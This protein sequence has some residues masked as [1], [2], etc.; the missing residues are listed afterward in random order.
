MIIDYFL[1]ED[2]DS[3]TF[4][5]K[6]KDDKGQTIRK[7]SNKKDKE[8]PGALVM[9][10]KKGYNRMSW[11]L[12][13]E[14]YPK[15]PGLSVLPSLN[16]HTVCPG[17]YQ[18]VLIYD[19]DSVSVDLVLQ[20]YPGIDA[21]YQDFQEQYHFLNEIESTFREVHESVNRVN[22]IK[23]QLSGQKA[24]FKSLAN[25]E[26]LAS[27]SDSIVKAIDQW[28]G[29]LIQPKQKT[30]QDIINFPNQLNAELLDLKSR[31]DGMIPHVS[32]GSRQ[33]LADLQGVWD[34]YKNQLQEILEISLPEYEKHYQKAELPIIIIP[35]N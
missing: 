2:M 11:D 20:S 3:T 26:E 27:M 7:Y 28:V 30:F 14:N 12:R 33:R 31:S 17:N 29:H 5:I 25:T 1:P 13:K 23:K 6:I 22:K 19:E 15:V 16:G 32:Q 24:L 10:S 18:A 35:K 8:N 21:S 4:H 9:T 34:N